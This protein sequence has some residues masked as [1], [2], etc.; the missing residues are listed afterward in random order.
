MRH[1]AIVEPEV[2]SSQLVNHGLAHVLHSLCRVRLTRLIGRRNGDRL[3]LP[4]PSKS[5]GAPRSGQ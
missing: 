1:L 4:I 3:F 5:S 2:V